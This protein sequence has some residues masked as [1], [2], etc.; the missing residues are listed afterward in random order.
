MATSG[1]IWCRSKNVSPMVSLQNWWDRGCPFTGHHT[2]SCANTLA[3]WV[4]FDLHLYHTKHQFLYGALILWR[5]RSIHL[6]PKG[7]ALICK[8]YYFNV[9]NIYCIGRRWIIV[10]YYILI[11]ATVHR[12]DLMFDHITT[13]LSVIS[14]KNWREKKLRDTKFQTMTTLNNK[15]NKHETKWQKCRISTKD[16]F[17]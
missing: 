1:N 12:Q 8:L 4:L 15:G 16:I 10:T 11:I 2:H 7:Y 14:L 17:V 9:E 3:T 5:W 13:S 6:L